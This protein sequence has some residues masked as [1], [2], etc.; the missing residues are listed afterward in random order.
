MPNR[1]IQRLFQSYKAALD[2]SPQPRK[3]RRAITSITYCRTRDMGVSYYA[4]PD[5]QKRWEQCHSC[6]HRSCYVCAQKHR[7]DWIEA[8]KQR[9]LDVPHFHVIF[10]LP[11][12]YLPL[13][14]YNEGLFARLLFRASQE[15]LQELL[16]DKKYGDIRPG[17]LMAL[18]T[19][20]RQLTLHPHT[21]CLV[22]AGGLMK[23]GEWKCVGDYLIPSAVLRRYY[24][25][26]V[27]AL[28]KDA[29]D[30]KRLVLPPDLSAEAFWR[31]HRSLYRKEWS[32]RIEERY[33]NGRGV[34]LYLARY[35]KGGP[36]R[37]EQI[38]RWDGQRLEMSYLDHRD[39]RIKQQ[40]LTPWQMIQR[41]LQHVPAKGV[42][43]VRYYGLYAPAARKRHEQ[44]LAQHGN[45]A[46]LKI[47]CTAPVEQVL[48]CC[49]DCGASAELLGER[50]RRHAKGISFIKEDGVSAVSDYVQQGVERDLERGSIGDS[51]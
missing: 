42:H 4:C 5:C 15:A 7:K 25:G 9:L 1:A 23:S 47:R 48:L 18:H 45:L 41:L 24:R 8:Q 10:T 34:M 49:K 50:W 6:R 20:G 39:K 2:E 28:L 27:Q 11:H 21:H 36:L 17:I 29:A 43:T 3:N 40:K 22:T 51:S 26:K 19:W 30:D 38:K 33:T 16:A 35:C 13:W 31:Q 46:G 12:E 37:P 44:V 14:R 32:V